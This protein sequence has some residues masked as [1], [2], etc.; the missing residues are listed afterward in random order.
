MHWSNL[1]TCIPHRSLF[2]RVKSRTKYTGHAAWKLDRKGFNFW[3]SKITPARMIYHFNIVLVH[4]LTP[5]TFDSWLSYKM[6]CRNISSW[7]LLS[8]SSVRV[9]FSQLN[10]ALIINYS[11]VKNRSLKVASLQHTPHIQVGHIE[12]H[13][14]KCTNRVLTRCWLGYVTRS[15]THILQGTPTVWSYYHVTAL[16]GVLISP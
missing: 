15:A 1:I 10:S 16:Q 13:A 9:P 3:S 4:I 6:H 8:H 5:N 7:N 14:R 11:R 12:V 2:D